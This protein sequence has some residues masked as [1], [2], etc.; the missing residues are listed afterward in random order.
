L[1]IEFTIQGSMWNPTHLAYFFNF[2]YFVRT[3]SIVVE[4]KTD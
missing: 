1:N 2:G 4:D 3:P